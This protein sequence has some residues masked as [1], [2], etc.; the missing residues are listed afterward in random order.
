MNSEVDGWPWGRDFAAGALRNPQVPA[1]LASLLCLSWV[2]VSSFLQNSLPCLA[3]QVAEN[4]WL[5][6]LIQILQ[7]L[8]SL[9]WVPLDQL[10]APRWWSHI[11]GTSCSPPSWRVEKSHEL[12]MNQVESFQRMRIMA[13]IY[14][15]WCLRW[16]DTE[17]SD[18]IQQMTRWMKNRTQILAFSF[19]CLLDCISLDL[20]GE[21][22]TLFGLT[23]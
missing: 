18:V 23:V 19:L 21:S 6:D 20:L 16:W 11:V 17:G 5:L 8:I 15:R 13:P 10:T 14:L 22:T 4:H 1:L 7:E 3:L 2:P 12:I 9:A